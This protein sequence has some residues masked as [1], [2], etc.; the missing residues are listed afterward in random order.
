LSVGVAQIS[1]VRTNG[2]MITKYR[3]RSILYFIC[4]IALTVGLVW[5]SY[6]LWRIRFTGPHDGLKALAIFGYVA[7]WFS[8]VLVGF[9]LARAKGYSRDFAG[10]MLVCL[11]I[12][13][14]C[15]PVVVVA[16][17]LYILFG[18]ED[19]SKNKSRHH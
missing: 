8:W 14:L 6:H 5:L 7:T 11:Y 10:S 1:L 19:K 17:P 16:F 18:L 4:S 15:F 9:N 13:G 12:I 3:N 2:N